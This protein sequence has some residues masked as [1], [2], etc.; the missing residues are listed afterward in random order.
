MFESNFIVQ[1]HVNRS[2]NC[3]LNVKK[4]IFFDFLI[5]KLI[6]FDFFDIF[7]IFINFIEFIKKIDSNDDFIDSNI[8][9]NL[10]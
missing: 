3:C 9:H 7:D 2:K 5:K 8:K 10:E 4:L 6:F 1:K